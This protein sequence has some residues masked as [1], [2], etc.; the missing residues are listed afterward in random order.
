MTG[1][2]DDRRS[3]HRDRHSTRPTAAQSAAVRA[4]IAEVLLNGTCGQADASS[5][6]AAA[7]R[8]SRSTTTRAPTSPTTGSRRAPP[9]RSYI[10]VTNAQH[11]DT[12]IPFTGFDTRFVPLHGYFVQAMDAMYAH[13]KNGTALPPSQVVRATPRGGVAGRRA[14]DHRRQRAADQRRA[15]GGQPDRLR[16][17]LAERSELTT[18]GLEPA[19]PARPAPIRRRPRVTPARRRR[20]RPGRRSA[21]ARRRSPRRT[22]R[23]HRR[24][25]SPSS[26][27]P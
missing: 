9:A 2:D 11:F 18:G 4:G 19:P 26:S 7:T 1:V 21:R 24:G 25:D 6:P 13:L 3:A 15:G 10:E 17:H 5:S 14:G 23:P 8:S 12:F 22:R 27:G 16:R 20:P